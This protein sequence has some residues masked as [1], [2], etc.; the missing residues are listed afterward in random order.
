MKILSKNFA[1]GLETKI[2]A[3]TFCC[4]KAHKANNKYMSEKNLV[5]CRDVYDGGFEVCARV[6]IIYDGKLLVCKNKSK[7]YYFFPGGHI[8]FGEKAEQALK[9]ELKE[10]LGIN[11][12]RFLYIGTVEN[13]FGEDGVRHHEINLVFQADIKKIS[14]SSKEDHIGFDF[15]KIKNLKR[16][17]IYPLALK[18]S[19]A[20]WLKD[21]KT[22]WA[23][24]R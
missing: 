5:K 6:V 15:I 13:I 3:V 9:R 24:Q 7:N 4:Q 8:E 21:K 11:V 23:S 20:K 10:E 16:E 22:F 12:S 2:E 1:R 19:L 14:L 17:K 18:N